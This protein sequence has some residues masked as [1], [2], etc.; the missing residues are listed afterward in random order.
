MSTTV[1]GATGGSGMAPTRI[2]LRNEQGRSFG[3]IRV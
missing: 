3:I 2:K 1:G